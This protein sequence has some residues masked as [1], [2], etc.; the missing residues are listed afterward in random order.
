ML[1]VL[2]ILLLISAWPFHLF[3]VYIAKSLKVS[4]F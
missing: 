4:E 1:E 2:Q 3:Q